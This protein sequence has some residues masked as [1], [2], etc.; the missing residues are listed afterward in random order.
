MKKNDL[1]KQYL[2]N[3]RA[4]S[5]GVRH[6]GCGLYQYTDRNISDYCGNVNV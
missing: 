1:P 2:Y 5:A 6:S 4:I 3:M